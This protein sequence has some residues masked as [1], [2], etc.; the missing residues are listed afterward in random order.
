MVNDTTVSVTTSQLKVEIRDSSGSLI[1]TYFQQGDDSETTGNLHSLSTGTYT[2]RMQGV[3]VCSENCSI[4]QNGNINWDDDFPYLRYE[5][6][7][8]W[9][10]NEIDTTQTLVRKFTGGVRINSIKSNPVTGPQ[11]IRRYQYRLSTDPNRSSGILINEP[12]PYYDMWIEDCHVKQRSSSSLVALGSMG[13]AHIG[14]SE[15]EVTFGENAED[16]STIYYYTNGIDLPDINYH[17]YISGLEEVIQA[18]NR[19]QT[20]NEWR[21]GHLHKTEHFRGDGTLLVEESTS[22]EAHLAGLSILNGV[23]DED[24]EVNETQIHPL[25]SVLRGSFYSFPA[26]YTISGAFSTHYVSYNIQNPYY[27]VSGWYHPVETTVKTYDASG[28]F[29]ESTRQYTY[30]ES[31]SSPALGQ[32]RMIKESISDGSERMTEYTYAHEVTNDGTGVNY[33]PMGLLNMLS[34]PYSVTVLD[35]GGQVLSKRWTLWGDEDGI[36]R[37]RSEWIW[38]GG[39]P[40]APAFVSDN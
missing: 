34:Q 23:I 13:G 35:G 17:K 18:F 20:S 39:D 36:W 1:A 25:S 26:N 16:G 32:L 30:E 37:P 8:S 31:S 7:I 28:L 5:F 24:F 3:R 10:E 12:A 9:M 29:V 38:T 2:I 6:D 4:Q 21:R 22:Y 27:L 33:T 15:V 40:M 19:A 14:Y 11:Q